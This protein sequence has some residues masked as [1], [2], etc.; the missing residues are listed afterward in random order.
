MFYK[1]PSRFTSAITLLQQSPV[2]AGGKIWAL[3]LPEAKRPWHLPAPSV[4]SSVSNNWAFMSVL[5]SQVNFRKHYLGNLMCQVSKKRVFQLNPG[6][7]SFQIKK[8]PCGNPALLGSK[9]KSNKLSSLLWDWN[10]SETFSVRSARLSP[11]GQVSA[12]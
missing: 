10:I 7:I 8:K 11:Q 5:T 6:L 12:L 2:V 1:W 3:G 9:V 4:G